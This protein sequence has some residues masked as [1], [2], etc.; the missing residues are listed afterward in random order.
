[1]KIAVLSP[2]WFPVPPEGYGGIEWVVS[3]LA[4]GLVA[5]GHEVT[6][7]A[8]GDSFT[9]GKL[10]SVFPSAPSEHIGTTWPELRHVLA[11]YEQADE[12]DIVNDHSGPLAAAVG[13]AVET[14]VVHTV[15]GPLTGE[16]GA[17][18][19]SLGRVAPRVGFVSLSYNQRKPLPDLNWV[20]NCHNALDLDAYPVHQER[21]EYL[22][23]LGRMSPDK[24][25]HRAV[26]V[27]KEAG[28]PLKIAGKMRE[29][30]E[31]EYFE[32]H[33]APHL[34]D[35]VEYLGETS[36]GKKVAL[37]Q[38]A[39]ATL[40]PIEWEEPFGLVMIESMA[41]GTPVIATRWGAV[42]EVIEE[43]RSGVIVDDYRQMAAALA[44]ADRLEPLECRRSM[45]ERFSAGRMVRDYEESYATMLERAAAEGTISEARPSKEV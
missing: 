31:R 28:V 17:L 3:L 36:H 15:H 9:K 22:L 40:F 26:E 44:D 21:G 24:G 38:N 18:Y 39:R 33:V 32:A 45:E 35:G 1:M 10:S 6:L 27:A 4:D 30:P 11:C 7:F 8:S 34:G 19:A 23:F 12:F 37:L 41:C 16:P 5:A 13:A 20:A 2:P 42:P 14:P 43:G 29:P 25:C